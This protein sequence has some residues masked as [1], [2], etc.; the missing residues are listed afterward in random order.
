MKDELIKDE[1]ITFDTA[2]LA[3]EKG[4]DGMSLR[5]KGIIDDDSKEFANWN[6]YHNSLSRPTQTLLQ[7]WLREKYW[8]EVY[9]YAE[10]RR[11][12]GTLEYQCEITDDRTNST[13]TVGGEYENRFKTYEKALE[14]GLIEALNLINEK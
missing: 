9:P 11:K 3:K 7:R 14:Q 8:I 1:L 13:G 2:K 4:F 10:G 6:S 12:N 5:F